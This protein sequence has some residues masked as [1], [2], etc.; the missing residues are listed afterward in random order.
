MATSF[1]QGKPDSTPPPSRHFSLALCLGASPTPCLGHCGKEQHVH[2]CK[3]EVWGLSTLG[4]PLTKRRGEPVDKCPPCL[5]LLRHSLH[6]PSEG[7]MG[8]SP[9]A[10]DSDQFNHIGL[11]WPPLLPCVS[12]P[13][14]LSSSPGSLPK[15]NRLHASPCL[16]F[17][18]LG[19]PRLSR[20]QHE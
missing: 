7:P 5:S 18:F 10:H 13:Q 8:L 11:C 2:M 20:S 4:Q 15:I 1:R 17:C 9:S 3:P 14:P 12:P 6:G 16:T 19:D